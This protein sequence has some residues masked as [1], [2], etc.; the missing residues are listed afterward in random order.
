MWLSRWV[1]RFHDTIVYSIHQWDKGKTLPKS[2]S[3]VAHLVIEIRQLLELDCY[4]N[5]LT[6]NVW[7]WQICI[8]NQ[9][10]GLYMMGNTGR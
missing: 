5:P 4:F 1:K 2:M 6:N 8:T 10:I 3:L 9:L 7:I